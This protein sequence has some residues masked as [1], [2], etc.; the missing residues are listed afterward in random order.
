[1]AK[2]T[3]LGKLS[4]N[5]V[6][7]AG[8]DLVAGD[9]SVEEGEFRFRPGKGHT[10]AP[11]AW[12][13]HSALA[14]VTEMAIIERTLQ[15]LPLTL[16]RGIRVRTL[17]GSQATFYLVGRAR[18]RAEVVVAGV[19][20][21]VDSARGSSESETPR[22]SIYA[23]HAEHAPL[24]G[25]ASVFRS[26]RRYSWLGG[27]LG[28]VVFTP[29]LVTALS[30]SSGEPSLV[31]A[32]VL[33]YPGN[34]IAFGVH[35]FAGRFI[36]SS[37]HPLLAVLPICLYL[38]GTSILAILLYAFYVVSTGAALAPL[39]FGLPAALYMAVALTPDR[40]RAWREARD[41]D[42]AAAALL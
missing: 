14:S 32:W 11:A 8:E 16:E 2:V 3:D 17:D 40:R 22:P 10:S 19:R 20:E 36:E 18:D 27:L 24:G 35:T 28:I 6:R 7:A 1:M 15:N 37:N 9:L 29:E 42:K 21:L 38:V 25:S 23:D 13:F 39:M 12:T 4:W 31:R 30:E 33:V 5:V 26:L 41:N 34:F